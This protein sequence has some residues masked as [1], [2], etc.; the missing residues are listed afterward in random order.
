MKGGGGFLV[1]SP[2]KASSADEKEGSVVELLDD[3]CSDDSCNIQ[4]DNG[5]EVPTEEDAA[6]S[7]CEHSN[8]RD[9][10]LKPPPYQIN[11]RKRSNAPNSAAFQRSKL[12]E[13]STA[14]Q[15][16]EQFGTSD[17]NKNGE[18][19]DTLIA[20]PVD[21]FTHQAKSNGVEIMDTLH[22]SDSDNSD[23]GHADSLLMLGN[24]YPPNQRSVGGA[25]P[26]H[27][28]KSAGSCDDDEEDDVDWEDGDS[29]GCSDHAIEDDE[30]QNANGDA[31]AMNDACEPFH[32]KEQKADPALTVIGENCDD[33]NGLGFEQK[34][35]NEPSIF[36]I[37]NNH[38]WEE[39]EKDLDDH[40]S[41][42][43]HHSKNEN[44]LEVDDSS[45][46]N[47]EKSSK[48]VDN[49]FGSFH[50]D[51]RTSDALQHAQETASKLTR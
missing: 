4:R 2:A 38:P 11:N 15:E 8:G 24:R 3:D 37:S 42:A 32:S 19:L 7:K 39:T 20:Q 22:T 46:S 18:E 21:K 27:G 44:V 30:I 34:N 17:N 47:D 13:L 5:N 28:I 51:R 33:A 25:E 41:S 48:G 23:N 12:M 49:E 1:A 9:T 6:P 40:D 31:R 26:F 35:S 43:V 36:H 29:G 50:P 14:G 10:H 45:A 16:W